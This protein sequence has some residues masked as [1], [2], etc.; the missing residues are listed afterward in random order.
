[1]H[2]VPLTVRTCPGPSSVSVADFGIEPHY[3][4]SLFLGEPRDLV[5]FWNFKKVTHMLN[6]YF[7]SISY[8][9]DIVIEDIG[10]VPHGKEGHS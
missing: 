3:P 1:M 4:D 5:F 8:K 7:A 6:K 10:G 2:L 9:D